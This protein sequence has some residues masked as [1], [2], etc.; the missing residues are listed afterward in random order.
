[1]CI[2]DRPGAVAKI[3]TVL[4]ANNLSIDNLIQNELDREDDAI[5]LVIVISNS[6]EKIMQNTI[7]D[8]Q[9]L[10]EIKN[11]ISHIRILDI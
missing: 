7:S 11:S 5:P 1:M 6:K 4:A 10:P 3:S 8:L 2:R 9:K